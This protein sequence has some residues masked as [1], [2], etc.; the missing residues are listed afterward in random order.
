MGDARCVWGHNILPSH[1]GNRRPTPAAH[2]S[3]CPSYRT[4]FH[5]EG[6]DN[7]AEAPD[8]PVV[9]TMHGD[10]RDHRLDPNHVRPDLIGEHQARMPV[11][12]RP[13]ERRRAP[14][15]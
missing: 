3:G 13:L 15:R 4:R 7:S 11:P 2:P 6:D 8:V 5:V 14:P 1:G 12:M 9:H 10:H